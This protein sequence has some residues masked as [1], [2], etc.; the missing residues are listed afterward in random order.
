[1]RYLIL[2]TILAGLLIVGMFGSRGHKFSETP[3]E[4]FNDMD[5]QARV[6]AQSSSDFFADGLGPR[7]KLNW[8]KSSLIEESKDMVSTAL[9]V[10]LIPVMVMVLLDLLVMEVRYQLQIYMKQGLPIPRILIIDPMV[11]CSV[12]LPWVEVLWVAMVERFLQKT[13]G[14][15]LRI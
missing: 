3:V 15:L 2:A 13:G 12:L 5:R 9:F 1:M 6:N 11:K 10:M 7:K 14:Q 4:I 8:T